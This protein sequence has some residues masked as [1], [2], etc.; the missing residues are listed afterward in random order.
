MKSLQQ[1]T[2]ENKFKL[3][4][5]E[6][7]L[8]YKFSNVL[9]LQQALIH[10]SFG[11]EQIDDGQNNETLE[12]I[13]D[14]VLDLAVSHMLFQK[15]PGIREG[16]LT[17]I[18]AGLVKE[19]TLASMAQTIKAG[20]F[21]MFGKGEQASQGRKKPSILASAFEAIV[22]AMYVDRGYENA[23]HFIS[24][25]FAPLLPEK[26]EKIFKEK[27]FA[28]DAKSILQEKLQEQFSQTPT[29]YLD[30]E[31]GPDHA[32]KFTV[33]VRFMAEILGTGS[34]SSKK[35][36]EQQAAETALETIDSWWDNL[37]EK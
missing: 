36:A 33:S 19:A 15:Y 11:F 28:D 10:S 1:L 2:H 17:K 29:Y 30:A 27:F 22:G 3:E 25:L 37:I 20:D 9:L 7:S 4:E 34:G 8:G 18:R 31:E 26:K 6:V 14:A 24:S 5:L 21:L 12:F 23:L 32:K 16:E 13:G 35:A